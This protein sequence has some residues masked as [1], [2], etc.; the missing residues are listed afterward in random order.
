MKSVDKKINVFYEAQILD[1]DIR[2]CFYYSLAREV[3]VTR[4]LVRCTGD[5]KS[6]AQ[7]EILH[8]LKGILFYPGITEIMQH[9]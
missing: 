4:S 7:N 1:I 2:T 3:S 8:V 9:C 5:T 6:K